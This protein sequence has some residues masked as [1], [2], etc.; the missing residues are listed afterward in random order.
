MRP[1][2]CLLPLALAAC[3]TVGSSGPLVESNIVVPEGETRIVAVQATPDR[4]TFRM[5]DGSRCIGIRP[6]GTPAGWSGATTDCGF[7]LPYTVTFRQTAVPQRFT[8]EAAPAG[9]GP[10]AEIFVTDTDGVRRLFAA[11]LADN[12]RFEAAPGA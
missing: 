9:T 11:P 3:Q 8:I 12:V 5:S 6:E 2:V 4:V 7:A 1:L 10:R